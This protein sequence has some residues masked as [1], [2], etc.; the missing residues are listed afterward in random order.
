M[1]D[2]VNMK[3][4]KSSL[5]AFT[6]IETI[7]TIAIFFI[8]TAATYSSY[9]KVKE[10]MEFNFATQTL[11]S[12]LR[13]AQAYGS[14][15]GGSGYVGAGVTFLKANPF[16]RG[17]VTEFL[18][19]GG[20]INKSGLSEGD[21]I[22]NGSPS[23]DLLLSYESLKSMDITRMCYAPAN[24]PN[25]TLCS[26]AS[27]H[28]TYSRLDTNISITSGAQSASSTTIFYDAGYIELKSDKLTGGNAY[29]CI[30]VYKS[31]AIEFKNSTCKRQSWIAS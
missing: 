13:T 23:S 25:V 10:T 14:N 4:L 15:I 3:I 19:A 5:R 7:V 29:R 31:G 26:V 21:K 12:K 28:F 16:T 8:V 27:L 9:P 11:V 6:L 2:R 1:T 20:P 17:A 30:E 18:D 22:Y 24:V